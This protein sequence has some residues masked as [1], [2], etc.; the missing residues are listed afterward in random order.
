[1]SSS[2]LFMLVFRD[3][4]SCGW[5]FSLNPWAPQD[6]LSTSLHAKQRSRITEPNFQSLQCKIYLCPFPGCIV[7]P[8]RFFLRCIIW[9]TSDVMLDDVSVTGERM[10]DIYVKGYVYIDVLMR[11]LILWRSVILLGIVSHV[12]R[13]LVYLLPL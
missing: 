2:A 10:S 1:M 9:N 12:T 13:F 8:Y 7:L 6:R 11:L 3:G 4:Y 5:I